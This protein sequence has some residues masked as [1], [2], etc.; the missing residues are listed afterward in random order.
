MK[1]VFTKSG[2]LMKKL[3]ISLVLLF[4]MS[5]FALKAAW[6]DRLP[7]TITQPDGS[8]IEC[9]VSGD[10]F[11]NWLHNDA[12]YTIIVGDDGFYYYGTVEG[13]IVVPTAYRVNSVN[14]ESVGLQPWAKISQREYQNKR[15]EFWKD[16]NRSTRAPHAGT[17]NNLVV[18]I[19]FNDQ[20][21]FTLP[22]SVYDGRF[23]NPNGSSLKTYYTEVSY[24]NLL[25]DS[26]HYPICDLSINLSYQDSHNRSYFEPYHAVNNPDGY[27]NS[28]Q[29]TAREHTLLKDAIAFIHDEVPLDLDIDADN[30]GY[31]D[32]MC[33]VI[34]GNSGAWADLLWAH[35]WVLYS[36][37]VYIHGKKVYDYTFQPE[38][39]NDV[40]TVCHEMFHSLGAPDLYHYTSNGI[41]PAG[42]W[43]LM[44]SGFGHMLGYMKYKYAN[45]TWI[46][47]IP[48]IT[49]A[50]TYTLNPLT[51]PTN[52]IYK[53]ASPNS[54]TQFFIVE[55][56]R[57]VPG[58]FEMNLPGSGLLVYRIDVT[59]GDGN[60]DG[61]PDEVYVYRPNGTTT[62][63]GTVN[64][65]YFAANVNRT[66]INDETNPSSFLQNGSPGGLNIFNIGQAGETISFDVLMGT[67]IIPE[68]LAD[69]TTVP[70]GGSVNF[71]DNSSNNPTSW[72]WSFPGGNP[73]TS[74]QPNP[75]V[76]Y[77]TLGIYDVSLEVSNSFGSAQINLEN[78]IIVGD[79]EIQV[80]PE[81]LNITLAPNQ[82]GIAD[83]KITNTGN[84]WLRYSSE[85]EF[86][87]AA[88]E[89][90][91]IL[92]TYG[93]I[94]FSR[95]G[96]TW[97]DGSLYI[98]G[99]NGTLN[100]YDTVQKQIVNTFDI[101]VQPFSIAY[102]GEY[103][104]IGENNGTVFA[105]TL[106][107]VATGAS[108]Q[109]PT[110]DIYSLTWD[111]NYFIVNL[112]GSS[113]PNFYRVDNQGNILQ[114]LTTSFEDRVTQL[115]WVPSHAEGN[116]WA[117]SLGKILHFAET[118][119][120]RFEVIEEFNAPTSLSYS[121]SHDGTDLWW[122]GLGNQ[123]YRFED[124]VQDWFYYL[125]DTTLIEANSSVEFPVYFKTKSL[126]I[127]VHSGMI[128][129]Y[130]NDP[131]NPV[132]EIPVNLIVNY[133]VVL[134]GDSNC[135]GVV[136]INDLVHTVNYIL[137]MSPIPFCFDN[138]DFNGDGTVD[139]NDLVL[140]INLI[141]EL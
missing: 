95:S 61:P 111:G 68:I 98:V 96:I 14:P 131:L 59:V 115:V 52:N 5:S 66:A 1:T 40:Q 102:D 33:F 23:N 49:T 138:A 28:S 86:I 36:Y 124:G 12:G 94:S 7:Y 116:L 130:C 100:V 74:T 47:E 57:K 70:V 139:A 48:E 119:D 45:H 13:E 20:P 137:G 16:A 19:R 82:N 67:E 31:V 80:T 65:A 141:M 125:D 108:F 51:S 46:T 37:N 77:E 69:V 140:T 10:E 91:T 112:I 41:A 34:R 8:T 121:I 134:P 42:P 88:G 22:R 113:S 2:N 50:G 136:N 56:R 129:L 92:G 79:P 135:D 81:A 43:D 90:G 62:N 127:G 32:N 126:E 85:K 101:H 6:F 83:L 75:I 117:S 107:G 58:T 26:H 118:D 15:D 71:T 99:L 73:A 35:R 97:A 3:K 60:A 9:F 103:L 25:I 38:N 87:S 120:G 109:L 104:W 17:L 18:Y 53:I 128:K 24:D 44:E 55:Y 64:Q 11:F 63:N 105:Y 27:K 30:D 110:N 132:V 4:F 72:L 123:L 39:Q 114:L 133:D 29:R 78:F 54:P 122:S 76:T 89:V 106:D 84:T 21:E 93:N